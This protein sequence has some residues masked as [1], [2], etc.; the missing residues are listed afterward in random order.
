MI[1]LRTSANGS[2]SYATNSYTIPV[3]SSVAENDGMILII[4]VAK[5][6]TVTAPAGWTLVGA[7]GNDPG[8]TTDTT[9]DQGY[10]EFRPNYLTN[11]DLIK[12][13]V[14][15]KV[16]AANEPSSYTFTSDE[17]TQWRYNYRVY[18]GS[19]AVIG[20]LVNVSVQACTGW[21]REYQSGSSAGIGI[22]IG[23]TEAS[24]YDYYAARTVQYVPKLTT[25]VDNA[26]I[27][28][29]CATGLNTTFSFDGITKIEEQ[30]GDMSLGIAEENQATAGDRAGMR[31][32]TVDAAYCA[33]MFLALKA[34]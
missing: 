32:R 2:S 14:Y 15:K 27:V 11:I 29:I 13:N 21:L 4:P 25:T 30:S 34:A 5:G 12:L 18:E 19:T 26:L 7:Q 10:A 20:D 9:A 23:G 1:T 28:G 24:P 22:G 6:V 3:P 8:D 16:A 31:V 17:P 33:V